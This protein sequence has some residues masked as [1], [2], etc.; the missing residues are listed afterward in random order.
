MPDQRP[1]VSIHQLRVNPPKLNPGS[2]EKKFLRIVEVTKMQLKR[3]PN[4]SKK[5]ENVTVKVTKSGA[6]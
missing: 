2:F 5:T 6:E 4:P 3:G 1:T